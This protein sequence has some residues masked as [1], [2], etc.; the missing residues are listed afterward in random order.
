VKS[1][2][3]SGFIKDLKKSVKDT[4]KKTF[5]YAKPV[6]KPLADAQGTSYRMREFKTSKPK[7]VP[8]MVDSMKAKK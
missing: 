3:N 5:D 8:T 4:F 2:A 7:N 1:K 6:V